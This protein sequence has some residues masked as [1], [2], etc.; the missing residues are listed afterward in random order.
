MPDTSSLRAM[1]ATARS[2]IL[3]LSL[4][5]P[6]RSSTPERVAEIARVTRGRLDRLGLDG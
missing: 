6:R 2:G 4:T 5:P 3:L 1:L